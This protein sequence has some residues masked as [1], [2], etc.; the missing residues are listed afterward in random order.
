MCEKPLD[1]NQRF[2]K[3]CHAAYMR[4]WRKN[5]LLT[6]VQ[7]LKDIARSYANVYLH[8]GKIH[9]K[10]CQKCG[11]VKSQMHHPNYRKP[12]LIIWLCRPCHI[13]EHRR[14]A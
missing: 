1:R 7:K 4:E 10:P 5:H 8:R 12:L 9:R 6:K 3:S 2:C 11:D 13:S 14:A